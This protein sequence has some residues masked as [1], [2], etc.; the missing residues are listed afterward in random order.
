MAYIHALSLDVFIQAQLQNLESVL[1]P[2]YYTYRH[3]VSYFI[4]EI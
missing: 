1:K 4:E 2:Y 3:T